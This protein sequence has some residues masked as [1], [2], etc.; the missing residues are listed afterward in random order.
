[1]PKNALLVNKLFP[2]IQTHRY[3]HSF[4]MFLGILQNVNY[5]TLIYT[6][7]SSGQPSNEN[8]KFEEK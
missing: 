1:M 5:E 4:T 7:T 2:Y 8:R 6:Y 3:H